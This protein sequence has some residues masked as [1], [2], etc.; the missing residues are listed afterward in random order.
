MQISESNDPSGFLP[1]GEVVPRGAKL[2]C[3]TEAYKDLDVEVPCG[4]PHCRQGHKNGFVVTFLRAD[5]TEGVG[6]IGH[7]CGKKEFGTAWEAQMLAHM[8]R[9]RV[10]ALKLQATVT[11]ADCAV[12]E[13]LLARI[14]P[15]ADAM[16]RIRERIGMYARSFFKLCEEA[17]RS[18]DSRIIVE[19]YQGQRTSLRLRGKS[20]WTRPSLRQKPYRLH[21]D[22]RIVRGLVEDPA[23]TVPKLGEALTKFGNGRTRLVEVINDLREDIQA[24]QLSHISA[25]TDIH[26]SLGGRDQLRIRDATLEWRLSTGLGSP[27]CAWELL[28]DLVS[29]PA[30]RDEIDIVAK[31]LA[32]A[33]NGAAVAKGT[34]G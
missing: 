17:A 20:F 29:F 6:A 15:I 31:L 30:F 11:L 27:N 5:E 24:L 14:L 3:I 1:F 10:V 19:D 23:T 34:K 32:D 33:S 21:A 28:A 13:P 12:V 9:E 25:L 22:I 4:L 2:L 7:H 18:A 16:D 26:G 8:A